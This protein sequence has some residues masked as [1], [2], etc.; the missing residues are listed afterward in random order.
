[1]SRH[2]M[3]SRA[4]IAVAA[5]TAF[6]AVPAAAQVRAAPVGAQADRTEE[7]LVRIENQ[8]RD[9]QGV[10]Y[11]VEGPQRP[12]GG[13]QSFPSGATLPGVGPNE[14]D[15]SLRVMEME[16]TIAELTGRVEELAFRVQ[17]QQEIIERL[18]GMGSPEF[19]APNTLPGI[20]GVQNPDLSTTG[21]PVDLL[22]TTPAE[23]PGAVTLPDDPDRAYDEAMQA[24]LA[25]DYE[26][27]EQR[28]EAYI[29]KFPEAPQTP[30]AKFTLGEIYLAT[31][32]NGEAARVFLDHV[33]SYKDDPRSPEAYLKLGVAF[34][35]L[36][37]PEEACRVFNAGVK[38]FPQMEA[39]LA[40]RYSEE[41]ASASCN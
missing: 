19:G 13:T 15:L 39:R 11:S 23:Q 9:M 20:D 35:R 30:E 31:G 34:T 26:T 32:A 17:R 37:R 5:L 38:K 27:A 41:R 22:G 8:L 36:N 24:V 21:G 2:T 18:E 16:R 3:F 33:S 6:T 25:A 14:A 29:G 10:L 28:L 4:A 40:T 1:M 7:R 12:L